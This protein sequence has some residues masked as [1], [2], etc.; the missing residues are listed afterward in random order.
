MHA[1]PTLLNTYERKGSSSRGEAFFLIIVSLDISAL[2]NY[3]P[4]RCDKDLRFYLSVQQIWHIENF[5]FL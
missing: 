5:A 4:N 2:F 1:P 3:K